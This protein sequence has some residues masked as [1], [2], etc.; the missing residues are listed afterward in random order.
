MQDRWGTYSLFT[1]LEAPG[2][3]FW[4]GAEVKNRRFCAFIGPV[5]GYLDPY[6]HRWR[7]AWDSQPP[8]SYCQAQYWAHFYW[9]YA[10]KWCWERSGG[11]CQACGQEV[12]ETSRRT[13]HLE[14]LG[15]R[16]RAWS[17]LNVP[18]NLQALCA[19][20]HGKAHAQE[21]SAALKKVHAQA[22]EARVWQ[23]KWARHL[24][25]AVYICLLHGE[26]IVGLTGDVAEDALAWA[27]V[28]EEHRACLPE[29]PTPAQALRLEQWREWALA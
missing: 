17:S 20:C 24:K 22:R 10:S 25:P 18:P 29:P 5:E 8:V 14:A 19:S 12:P 11:K 3:C 4:C 26:V 13:H 23:S 2:R 9:G 15:G 7:G 28:E 27:R 1:G 6:T 21:T 16:P